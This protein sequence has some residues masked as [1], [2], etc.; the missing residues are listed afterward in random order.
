[1]FKHLE[2]YISL[3]KKAIIVTRI[4]FFY[5]IYLYSIDLQLWIN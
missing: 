4:Q 5:I 3:M 2:Q 1:M